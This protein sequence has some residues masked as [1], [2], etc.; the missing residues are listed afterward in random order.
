MLPAIAKT[1]EHVSQ[2][3]QFGRPLGSFQ[4]VQHRWLAPM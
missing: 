1:V 2:R 3:H 4:A